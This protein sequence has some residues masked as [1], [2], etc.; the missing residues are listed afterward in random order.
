[1]TKAKILYID[2]ETSPN[3][4]M[5]WACGKQFVNHQQI[6]QDRRIICASYKWEGSSKVFNVDW[7]L[8]KQCDKNLCIHLSKVLA[9]ADLI[10]GQNHERFDIKWINTRVAYHGL[11]PINVK[12][13]SMEDTLKLMRANFYLNSNSLAYAAKYFGVELKKDG[14]GFSRVKRILF[15]KDKAS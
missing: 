5:V 12:T 8:G 6:I 1:M 2:I 11:D 13:L 14:G 9:S 3:I 7:G 15:D 10:I 4:A